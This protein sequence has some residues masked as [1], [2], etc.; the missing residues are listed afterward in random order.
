MNCSESEGN[1]YSQGVKSFIGPSIRILFRT[2]MKSYIPNSGSPV[3]IVRLPCPELN[4]PPW[5]IT[6]EG[7]KSV[8]LQLVMCSK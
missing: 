6:F 8:I 7:L 4:M 5:M 1:S 2:D 3:L